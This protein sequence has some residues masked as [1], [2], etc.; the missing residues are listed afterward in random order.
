[1]SE[2]LIQPAHYISWG[3]HLAPIFLLSLQNKKRVNTLISSLCDRTT[4]GEVQKHI[5]QHSLKSALS[6][7]VMREISRSLGISC[8]QKHE[9]AAWY[10]AIIWS[11]LDK[12]LDYLPPWDPRFDD[13][14]EYYSW[15]INGE[16]QKSSLPFF[17]SKLDELELISREYHKL[18]QTFPHKK[19]LLDTV[20]EL[21]QAVKEQRTWK[22]RSI[23]KCQGTLFSRVWERI[24][25]SGF[26][27]WLQ[28]ALF[29][30]ARLGIT[31]VFPSFW[32]PFYTTWVRRENSWFRDFLSDYAAYMQLLDDFLDRKKDS[33]KWVYTF[34]TQY[35]ENI[36]EIENFIASLQADLYYEFQKNWEGIPN[37]LFSGMSAY[38]ILNL[39]WPKDDSTTPPYG[40]VD[41]VIQS[42]DKAFS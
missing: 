32:T 3:L 39:I 42:S 30:S 22:P 27:S 28:N 23:D 21:V 5:K 6:I 12:I 11:N 35:P 16:P 40:I 19:E 1:M 13:I 36:K 25:N 2:R 29:L 14:L 4:D 8:T 7:G 18:I 15:I 41:L 17:H 38:P 33:K 37:I 24:K 20:N 9:Q 34:A 10:L 31:S 26:D